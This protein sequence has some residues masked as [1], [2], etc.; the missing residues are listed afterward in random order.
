MA[1]VEG[2]ARE[3]ERERSRILPVERLPFTIRRVQADEELWKAVR[4][5]QAAYAR[6]VP[7]FART[8]AV[9]EE[10]DYASDAVVLLAISKLDGTALGSVRVQSNLSRALEV[11]SSVELPLWLQVHR[12]AEVTRLAVGEGRGGS[13][14]K[15]ALIKACFGYCMENRLDWA[16]VTGRSPIDRQY[17]QLLFSDVFAD[18]R[19]VALHHVGNLPHRI[20]AVDINTGEE[21]WAAA[22]HPLLDFFRKKHH[23]DIDISLRPARGF[24]KRNAPAVPLQAVGPTFG[25]VTP[26]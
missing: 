26:C 4:V 12:L 14:V 24:A 16:V 11:E 9:P 8:L 2:I 22:Q 10:C 3:R 25:F 23:P 20:M 7:E 21:R 19:P 5:R 6:H 17:E 15:L 18:K 13:L 1:H